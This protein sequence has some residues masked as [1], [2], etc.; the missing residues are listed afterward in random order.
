MRRVVVYAFPPKKPEGVV[1]V[2]VGRHEITTFIGEEIVKARETLAVLFVH[3]V[4]RFVHLVVCSRFRWAK[5]CRTDKGPF[6]AY[7]SGQRELV[8][9]AS[10]KF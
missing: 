10:K 5:L 7:T 9:N 3:F 8:V 6:S 4:S 1:L 2:D